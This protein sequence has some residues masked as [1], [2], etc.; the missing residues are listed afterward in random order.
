MKNYKGYVILL[1]IPKLCKTM[2]AEPKRNN[3]IQVT[4][5]TRG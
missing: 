5:Q 3:E 1:C 2:Y 4:L